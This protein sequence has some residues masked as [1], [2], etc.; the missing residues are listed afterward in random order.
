[1]YYSQEMRTQLKGERPVLLEI[2]QAGAI[3]HATVKGLCSAA[4]QPDLDFQAATKKIHQQWMAMSMVRRYPLLLPCAVQ[5]SL[6]DQL[7]CRRTS[8][9]TT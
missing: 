9:C 6:A 7:R 5:T 4:E 8:S 3:M 2:E 1:M